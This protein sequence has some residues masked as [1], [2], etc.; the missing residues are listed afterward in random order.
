MVIKQNYVYDGMFSGNILIVGRTA[1]GKTYFTQKLALN[2]FFGELKKVEWI[3]Y[4]EMNSEREAEIESCFSRPAEFHYPKELE[5]FNDLLDVF[6]ACSKTAAAAAVTDSYSIDE[7][8]NVNIGF[9]KKTKRDQLIVMDKVSGL[10]DKSAKFASFLIVAR[11][12]NYIC[13]YIFHT[14]YPEKT[15]LITT[16][17]QTNVF[18]NF[19][20]S[21][22]LISVQKTLE[23]ACIRKTR[24]YIPQ[25]ALWISRLFIKLANRD[26]RACL[27]LDCSGINKDSPERFRT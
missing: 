23:G 11:K 1:R 20:E 17:S 2:N 6:K 21:V 12:F 4:I 25:S 27:T 18:D 3:S 24:K 22:P 13:I 8:E 5:K 19:P 16:F 9:G 7:K 14:I 10:A 15:I 26:D